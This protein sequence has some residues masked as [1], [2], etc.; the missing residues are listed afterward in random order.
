TEP[1]RIAVEL[2]GEIDGRGLLLAESDKPVYR[3]HLTAQ[4]D[5][6]G[7]GAGT[8]VLDP[9]PPLVDEFGFPVFTAP[10]PQ[11]KRECSLKL[12]NRKVLL[13]S[14][15][16]AGTS[17]TEV[18]WRL[19]KITGPT[20]TSRL[21]L[22]TEAGAGWAYARFLVSDQDGRGRVSVSLQGPR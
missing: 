9:T 14:D 18:E 20:I 7:E 12:V 13:M 8:L 3:I 2:S 1:E 21:T 10:L 19:Y 15:P 22:A 6:R 4:V 17:S 5:K 16:P 11:V